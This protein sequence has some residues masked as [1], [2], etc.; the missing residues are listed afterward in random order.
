MH[1]IEPRDSA[2][3]SSLPADAE[4][5]MR[6]ARGDTLAFQHIMR[7]HNRLLFRTGRSILQ[8]D[9]ETQ[10]ALQEAYLRAW[11]SLGSFRAEARLSTWLVRIVVNEA[12]GRLRGRRSAQVIPLDTASDTAEAQGETWMHADPD[13]QPE[14]QAMRGEFRSLIETR[15]D[16]LPEAF[17]TVFVLRAVED[18]SIEEVA[19]ALEIPEATVRSRFFRARGLL[20]EALSREVDLAIGDAFSFA[21]QRCDDIVAHVMSAITSDAP[22][23]LPGS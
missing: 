3:T 11:R 9:E 6:A 10:D 15:I 7:R 5:A 23:P 12:L 18:M 21:G 8:N 17:R 1:N 13:E 2:A 14:R 4:L 16:A 22:C 20:R 19:A